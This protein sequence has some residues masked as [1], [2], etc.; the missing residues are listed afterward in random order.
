MVPFAESIY[1]RLYWY[2]LNLSN[3]R[4]G[5]TYQVARLSMHRVSQ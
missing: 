3:Y 1:I 2:L 4:V 5:A